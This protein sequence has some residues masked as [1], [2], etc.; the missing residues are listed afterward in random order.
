MEHPPWLY[1]HAAYVHVPFCA[2]HCGYCDFA[3]VAGQDHLIDHYL[4]ALARE[5]QSLGEPRPVRTLFVGGGTPTH[6]NAD[7]LERLLRL[8]R[9]WLPLSPDDGQPAGS[10]KLPAAAGPAESPESPVVSGPAVS[11]EPGEWSIEATPDSLDG[12]KLAL[13]RQAGVTRVSIGVQTFHPRHLAVLERRHTAAQTPQVVEQAL[14]HGFVVSLDLIFGIP[15]SPL[16]DWE[17][18]LDAAIALNPH[19][20]STYGLTYE[21]GTPLWKRRHRGQVQPVPEEVEAAMYEAAIDRL[22]AAGFEQYE[23][24][25]FARPGYQCRHNRVYWAN[26]AYYGFGVG[27][28]RYLFGRR[29]LNVRDTRLYIRKLLSGES[30]TFQS[31]CL[32]PRERAMETLAVQLRRRIG[33]EHRRFVEQTGFAVAELVGGTLSHLVAIGLL[34][35]DGVRLRLTRR[36]LLVADAVIAELMAAADSP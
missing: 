15:G 28:A 34:D 17:A 32:P 24:S 30:P 8:L 26:E 25:N 6:L 20:I 12:D 18:D 7:Q 4:E 36:G 22:E 13:L 33:V 14:R 19:H 35:D 31:E 21:K 29:E 9:Q 5:L 3:V 23:I 10:P 27:A 11:L 1:P 2:H 16:A